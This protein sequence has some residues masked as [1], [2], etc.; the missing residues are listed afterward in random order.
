MFFFEW[1][2]IKCTLVWNGESCCC[3]L[4]YWGAIPTSGSFR[5]L[6][7]FRWLNWIPWLDPDIDSGRPIPYF[8]FFFSLCVVDPR[9]K[10][11]LVIP[12]LNVSRLVLMKKQEKWVF[13][14]YSWACLWMMLFLLKLIWEWPGDSIHFFLK[15]K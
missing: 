15:K 4:G 13:G 10:I 6:P 2:K 7:H 14:L 1:I 3:W 5:C 9:P 12:D 8:F 11:K